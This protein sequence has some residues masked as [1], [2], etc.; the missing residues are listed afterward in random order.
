[1][2]VRFGCGT[3]NSLNPVVMGCAAGPEPERTAPC[4]Q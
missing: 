2:C 3:Y 4:A 1:M